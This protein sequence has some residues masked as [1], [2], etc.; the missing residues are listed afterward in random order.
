MEADFGDIR[1]E[2]LGK[3]KGTCDTASARESES[4]GG[5]RVENLVTLSL[6]LK[7][8]YCTLQRSIYQM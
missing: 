4:W 6:V 8:E 1:I 2:F 7:L 3:F 5:G